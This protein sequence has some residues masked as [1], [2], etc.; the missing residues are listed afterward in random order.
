MYGAIL[1]DIIGSP[2]EFDRGD[3]TKKFDLF[4]EGCDFTDD[5]VMTIAVGEAL[6]AVGPEAA[7]KEI[8]DA[9]VSNMQDWGK[10]Y[11]HA[12][13]G[14][15]FRHWLKEKNPKPYGSYGNGSAMRVSAAG[16]LY[17]SI[18]RTREVARAT[19]NVTHNHPE[20]I[21]GAEAT[22]S[23]IYMARNGSSKEEIK[24]YIEREFHYD[25]SRTLDNIRPYYHHVESC[26]ET[27]PEAI[28]AFLESK[29]FEDAVRNAVSLG[30]D[31][32]TAFYG[33]PAVLIAEC[34]S[35][36]DKGLMTD[37][38]DEF[39]HVL[40]RSMDTYS[41]E[42]DETQ[43]NQMIEAAI[44][45]YY[46]QQD[47]NGM[48]LFME[49]MVTRMQ[50][51]GEVIVPY[52]TENSFMSEEQIGKVK[53]GDT[54]LL[55]HDVR[56]KIETVKDADEKEWIGVFTS[57]EEMHKGSAGNVQMNQSIES[58]LR[59]ALNWEQVN[60]IVINPFGKYIQMTKKMI[61]LL[62]NGYEYY[63]N[64]RKSKDDEN[65]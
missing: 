4:S 56:L 57:S 53:A 40:G 45:Q 15:S 18:E 31:T 22:A 48:L 38:L 58:I 20:G 7:V 61:E 50:Q 6:L 29:D 27:V 65:N 46:I 35:R 23:A 30:G 3:K 44:D 64:E 49:V 55:D 47:K 14:G 21:K 54:I 59:L 37:V 52:I 9:V 63:E 62:I 36:I 12:G 17:D 60:G 25:L 10:R 16:W 32:D 28:I 43:A 33:I 8:E 1:G 39:D 19:A 34:K 51:A 24:E 41:D 11:P 42:M 26:Q 13:Y 2:F 5:S